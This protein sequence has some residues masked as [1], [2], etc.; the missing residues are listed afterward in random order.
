MVKFPPAIPTRSIAVWI[1]LLAALHALGQSTG[2]AE[3]NDQSAA[4][5]GKQVANPLS[6]MWLMQFQQ[7]NNWIGMPSKNG[8]RVESN[9]QFQPLMPV[10]LTA[11]WNLVTRP[12]LQLF[13]SEPYLDQEGRSQRTTAF[14]DMVFALALSPGHN[15]VG[16][17][18][19]AAGPTFVFP[20]ATEPMLGQ[21]KWQFGPTAAVGYLGRSFIA[22][23]FPQQWFSIGGDG[24]KTSQMSTQYAFIYF[25]HNGWSIGTNPDMLVDWE[26]PRKNRVTFP[27]GLQVGK[28][29][30]VGPI[31]V[32]IDLQPQYYPVHPQIYGSKW[33]VQL[34]ITPVIPSLIKRTI[35]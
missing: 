4:E 6:D 27:V 5:L 20:T 17:W 23:V 25:F 31:P 13:S 30:K 3:A 10:K 34:Q 16:N 24:P 29:T 18:L 35:F 2:V 12:V 11:N 33:G 7:N 8:D 9:L 19:L 32:K 28:L 15:L 26:A 14:G 1:A 21:K 22:Y